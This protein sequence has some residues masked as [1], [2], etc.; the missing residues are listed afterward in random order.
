MLI[1]YFLNLKFYLF[2]FL[3]L[4]GNKFLGRKIK[5]KNFKKFNYCLLMIENK[6]LKHL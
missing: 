3:K 1:N 6:M 5:N 2:A 4:F